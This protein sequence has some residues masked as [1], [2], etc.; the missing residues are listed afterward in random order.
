M[1]AGCRFFGSSPQ[2]SPILA[3]TA[4]TFAKLAIKLSVLARRQEYDL[5]KHLSFAK[6]VLH[7]ER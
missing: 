2:F 4:L 6:V 7:R 5:T 1:P 3:V